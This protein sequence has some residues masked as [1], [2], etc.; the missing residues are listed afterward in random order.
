MKKAVILK[1]A[2]SDTQMQPYRCIHRTRQF[3]IQLTDGLAGYP[4]PCNGADLLR[5]NLGIFGQAGFDSSQQDLE[6]IHT[7]HIRR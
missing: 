7:R 3:F 6:R 5:L 1:T 2:D 4:F